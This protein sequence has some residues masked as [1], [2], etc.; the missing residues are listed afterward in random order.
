GTGS[1]RD[2]SIAA[3]GPR[4]FPIGAP[5]VCASSANRTPQLGQ[6]SASAGMEALHTGHSYSV[7]SPSQ[8]S[9]PQPGQT[10]AS[11]LTS[12]SQT[13]HTF[14]SFTGVSRHLEFVDAFLS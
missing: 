5:A 7:D 11:A 2:S 10:V 12:V 13:G 4:L 3:A 1:G 8:N 9:A 6:R 14:V